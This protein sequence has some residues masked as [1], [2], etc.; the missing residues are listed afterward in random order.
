MADGRDG[1]RSWRVVPRLAL[2]AMSVPVVMGFVALGAAVIVGRSVRGVAREAWARVP[3]WRT[4]P[5]DR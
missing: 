3:S 2:G 5:R 4:A 1:W